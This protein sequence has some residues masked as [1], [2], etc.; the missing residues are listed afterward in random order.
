MPGAVSKIRKGMME[1]KPMKKM[2]KKPYGKKSKKYKSMG[3][4]HNP[5]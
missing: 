2:K 1:D 5:Y 4:S 3:K